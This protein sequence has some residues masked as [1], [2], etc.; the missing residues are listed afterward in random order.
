M[1]TLITTIFWSFCAFLCSASFSAALTAGSPL[2]FTCATFMSTP[3]SF[4]MDARAIETLI[5]PDCKVLA[6]QRRGGRNFLD[7]PVSWGRNLTVAARSGSPMI[8]KVLGYGS[9]SANQKPTFHFRRSS[10][11]IWQACHSLSLSLPIPNRPTSTTFFTSPFQRCA[12]S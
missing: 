10:R 2:W 7:P 5:S 8:G 1:P 9:R 4:R 6:T 12:Q 3:I 11:S